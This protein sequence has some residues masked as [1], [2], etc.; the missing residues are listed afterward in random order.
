MT[1]VYVGFNNRLCFVF[2]LLLYIERESHHSPIQYVTCC[3]SKSKEKRRSDSVLTKEAHTYNS[4]LRASYGTSIMGKMIGSYRECAVASTKKKYLFN[5][6]FIS[7]IPSIRIKMYLVLHF[8]N[9]IQI[10]S[11]Y[12]GF[13]KLFL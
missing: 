7:Q 5:Q 11:F 4:P 2:P 9:G 3:T 8:C 12:V 13:M 6:Y 10:H 1:Q